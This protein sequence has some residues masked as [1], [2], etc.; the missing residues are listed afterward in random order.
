MFHLQSSLCEE[1][2]SELRFALRCHGSTKPVRKKDK[3]CNTASGIEENC[4][5][6]L[7]PY[8][9]YGFVIDKEPIS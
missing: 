1:M 8:Q 9:T 6:Q 2:A 5:P 7:A 3:S 4:F